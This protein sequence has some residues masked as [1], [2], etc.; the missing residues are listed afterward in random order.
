M[1]SFYVDSR[2]VGV[3]MNLSKWFPVNVALMLCCMMT[4][5]ILYVD[6]V[7]R[8]GCEGFLGKDWNSCVRMVA[9]LR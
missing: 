1:Q 8:K 7:V 6:G 9:G 2:V 4:G 5:F 3:E